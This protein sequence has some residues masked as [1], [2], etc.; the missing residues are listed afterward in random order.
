MYTEPSAVRFS[1]PLPSSTGNAA[2]PFPDDVSTAVIT[3]DHVLAVTLGAVLMPLATAMVD[4]RL[5]A[6]T[7]ASGG[8]LPVTTDPRGPMAILREMIPRGNLINP[9]LEG[10]LLQIITISVA[11]GR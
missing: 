8:E 7:L 11:V 2:T 5:A 10:N 4:A 1:R 9:F 3:P 6:A